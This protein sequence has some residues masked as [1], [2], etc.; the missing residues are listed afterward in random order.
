MKKVVSEEE[1]KD[2]KLIK[3]KGKV[4]K[5]DVQIMVRHQRN[6]RKFG[7]EG[8]PLVGKAA[9]FRQ[10]GDRGDLID[11]EEKNTKQSVVLRLKVSLK[12]R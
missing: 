7:T 3:V 9:I 10:K 1:L 12:Q 11:K 5:Q 4:R 8:E 2:R 6:K